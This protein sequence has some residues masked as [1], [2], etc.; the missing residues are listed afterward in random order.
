MF[1]FFLQENIHND[2]DIWYEH[3]AHINQRV[4]FKK[5][6]LLMD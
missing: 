1:F 6:N 3:L 5:K 2:A 4:L